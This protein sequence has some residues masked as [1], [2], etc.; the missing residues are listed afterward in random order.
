MGSGSPSPSG[1]Y[2]Q[3]V[4]SPPD[5]QGRVIPKTVAYKAP[6]A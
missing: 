4:C 2:A 3:T 1:E 6:G 5:E